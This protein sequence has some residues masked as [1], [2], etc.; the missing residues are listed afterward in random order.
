MCPHL[1]ADVKDSSKVQ[2]SQFVT[3][4]FTAAFLREPRPSGERAAKWK[5]NQTQEALRHAEEVMSYL[6]LYNHVMGCLLEYR[7]ADCGC[8]ERNRLRRKTFR[9]A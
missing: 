5:R 7:D 1:R 2:Q 4:W 8:L 3:N 9:P 6:D